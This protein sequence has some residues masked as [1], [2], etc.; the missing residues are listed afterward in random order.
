MEKGEKASWSHYQNKTVVFTV[1][2]SGPFSEDLGPF[3]LSCYAYKF[4]LASLLSVHED[5]LTEF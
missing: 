4:A 1:F 5:V 3:D 2:P